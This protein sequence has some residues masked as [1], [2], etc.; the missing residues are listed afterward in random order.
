MTYHI[1]IQNVSKTTLPIS[2]ETIINWAKLTL[3]TKIEKAE[4]TI[5][6]VDIDEITYLNETYRKQNKPTNVLAFSAN[7][8]T[9]IDLEFDLLGDVIICPA[10]IEK[11]SIEQGKTIESHYA[12]M[13]IHGILHLLGFDHIEIEEAL[14][15]QN[16]ET[17]LLKKLNFP[18]PYFEEENEI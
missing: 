2:N 3:T 18:D 13:I 17:K 16:L 12:L 6:F 11:E 14:I 1:D 9:V 10:V 7:L 5:R 8:P 4:L 15:M